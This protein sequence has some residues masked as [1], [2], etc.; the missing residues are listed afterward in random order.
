MTKRESP[1]LDTDCP[2]DFVKSKV[3]IWGE[4]AGG[5][6]VMFQVS[7]RFN[8]LQ[9]SH[10]MFQLVANGGDNQGLFRA[11]IGDSASL[12]AVPRYNESYVEGI[13]TQFAGLAYVLFFSSVR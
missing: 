11:A 6:A 1:P 8:C 9:K 5:G 4:S 2:P 12:S 10:I 7:E 3:T 13:Y